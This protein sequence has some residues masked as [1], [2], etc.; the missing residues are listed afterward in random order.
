VIIDVAII[1]IILFFV[2]LGFKNG[3]IRTILNTFGWI[4]AIAAAYFLRKPFQRFLADHTTVYDHLYDKTSRLM[5]NLASNLTGGALE[6]GDAT[7]ASAT[8][9][10]T[11]ATGSIPGILKDALEN[12]YEIIAEQVAKQAAD[13]LLAIIAFLVLLFVIKLLLYIITILFS[14]KHH[15]RGIVGGLDGIAGAVLG[16]GQAVILILFL[17]AL[18][19]PV[20]YLINPDAYSWI[21]HSLDRSIFSQY[22][23]EHNPLLALVREYIPR[24]LLPVEWFA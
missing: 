5:E 22:I 1:L 19:L 4:I 21:V 3:F 23:Y 14:K 10:A 17:L 16:L 20:S 8:G 2:F 7:S 12:A 13:I 11:D 24:D 6:Q 18:M 15:H 9:G